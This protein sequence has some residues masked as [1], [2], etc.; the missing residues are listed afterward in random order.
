MKELKIGNKT[1]R[2]PI[3]QGGMG[4]GVS[5]SNLAGHV[6]KEGGVGI[7]STV[8]IGYKDPEFYNNPV[9]CNRKA[10]K[11]HIEYAKKIAEGNGLVGVNVMCALKHYKEHV[12]TAAEAGADIVISGAGLPMD[13]PE[14]VK[15]YDTCIAPIVS[16]ARCA[17]LIMKQWLKKYD[18]LPDLIVIEGPKA[19]GH[20]GFT[21]EEAENE[22]NIDL[23]IKEIIKAA[24][25]FGRLKHKEIPV[26][27]AGGIFTKEDIRY[28]FSLGAAGVQLGSRFVATYEC[29][30][31]D[32]FKRAYVDAKKDDIRIIKSPVGMPGRA[33]NNKWLENMEGGGES[34]NKCYQ[35]ISKCNPL[36][37]PY[38]IT[39]AL[40]TAVEG[41]VEE[42]LVFCGANV[43]KITEIVSVRD[44][45]KE[46]WGFANDYQYELKKA[47]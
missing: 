40:I 1:A 34:V 44:L 17:R 12:R 28:A 33:I 11:E 2:I 32:E 42:G 35:C 36:E 19:G 22:I 38:C 46:L 14:L 16:S 20:L 3:I 24:D 26:V 43:D 30:A 25:E 27:V 9:E 45:I 7:I 29:D 21:K 18:R 6:A 10:I 13:L 37:T 41:N 4:I 47:I 31:S 5:L 39:K 8:Q 15:G 23:E